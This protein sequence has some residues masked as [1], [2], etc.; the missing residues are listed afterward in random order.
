MPWPSTVQARDSS[1]SAP[2]H[3]SDRHGSVPNDS[4]KPPPE[5]YRSRCCRL[6]RDRMNIARNLHRR[7]AA[8]HRC[9]CCGSRERPSCRNRRAIDHGRRRRRLKLRASRIPVAGVRR[10]V[11]Q[12]EPRD[13]QPAPAPKGLRPAKEPRLPRGADNSELR[14]APT[15]QN[16]KPGLE[17]GILKLNT[18]LISPVENVSRQEEQRRTKYIYKLTIH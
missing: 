17:T 9:K 4:G 16:S 11:R 14:N 15:S 10:C 8:S 12:S 5:A 7:A 2:R 3:R 18:V 1:Q 6:H 13:L